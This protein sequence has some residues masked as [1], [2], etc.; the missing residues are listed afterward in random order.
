[1]TTLEFDG[2]V[3][4]EE[5]GVG[6]HLARLVGWWDSPSSKLDGDDIPQGDGYYEPVRFYRDGRPVTVQGSYLGSSIADAQRM[7]LRLAALQASG[8]AGPF[9]VSEEVGALTARMQ[10][11]GKVQLPDQLYSE[12]FEFSFQVSSADA[13]RYGDAV[14]VFTGL[15]SRGTGIVF[16]ETG[17]TETAAGSGLYGTGDDVE[18][19]PGLYST[20][21]AQETAP[22]SALYNIPPRS[23]GITFPITF[24]A[25]GST[26]RVTAVNTGTAD[27]FSVFTVAGG[28]FEGGFTLVHVES[29][30]QVRVDREIPMG[31]T[32]VIDSRKGTVLLNGTSP[33]PGSLTR[34]EWWPVP[35]GGTATVQF[36]ANGATSGTP[37]LTVATAPASL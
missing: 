30:R 5:M 27:T 9:R 24:G 37:T 36:L 18:V 1:M 21:A 15:A 8:E 34:S 29:G 26:G 10:M 13:Y 6:L 28:R 2:L 12:R 23:G 17:G 19:S 32:V 14:S 7:R 4:D 33:I 35:A 11:A 31:S 20:G 3:F 22:G 25:P 16:P